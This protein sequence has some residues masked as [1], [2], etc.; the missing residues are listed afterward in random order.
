[1]IAV[2]ALV[3]NLVFIHHHVG[4]KYTSGFRRWIHVL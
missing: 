2:I 4:F 3:F 1:M